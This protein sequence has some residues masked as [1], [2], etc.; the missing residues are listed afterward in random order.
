MTYNLEFK[1]QAVRDLSL[2][3]Q[4]EPKAFAKA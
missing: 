4:N 1:E 3:V 2:L